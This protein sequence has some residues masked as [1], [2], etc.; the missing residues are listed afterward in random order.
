MNYVQCELR[1]GYKVDTT[2]IEE[3]YAVVGKEVKRKSGDEEWDLGWV[4]TKTYGKVTEEVAKH[5][6]DLHKYHR[7]ATDI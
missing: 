6:R 4:V 7:K 1:K 3:K 5:M 2:W